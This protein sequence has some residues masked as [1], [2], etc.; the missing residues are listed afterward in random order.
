MA[1]SFLDVLTK[2]D[3]WAIFCKIT[4]QWFCFLSFTLYVIYLPIGC[5][6]TNW[7]SSLLQFEFLTAD[8]SI[9]TSM[10]TNRVSNRF[11]R[12]IEPP[13]NLLNFCA[14]VQPQLVNL[15]DVQIYTRWH[16]CIVQCHLRL[17][18]IFIVCVFHPVITIIYCNFWMLLNISKLRKN[19]SYFSVVSWVF[20]KRGHYLEPWNWSFYVLF[21][22]MGNTSIKR[23]I[24]KPLVVLE[25]S[26][27]CTDMRVFSCSLKWMSYKCGCATHLWI[28]NL[29]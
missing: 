21:C 23:S 25:I 13:F 15:S 2:I 14:L 18:V 3:F 1:F 24:L 16:F 20:F 10:G 4:S 6:L 12:A 8:K 28:C 9:K 27:P 7:I 29:K 22:L 11:L 5:Y 26:V 19:Y 17:D